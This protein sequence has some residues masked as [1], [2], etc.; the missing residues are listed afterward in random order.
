MEVL[1]DLDTEARAACEE[2]GVKMARAGTVE[3]HP[4]MIRMITELIE[5]EPALC[6][7]TCCLAPVRPAPRPRPQV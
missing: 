6:P 5:T 4:A 2:L 1:Y 3:T 7:A